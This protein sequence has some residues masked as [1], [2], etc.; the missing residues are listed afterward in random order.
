MKQTA[1]LMFVRQLLYPSIRFE[2]IPSAFVEACDTNELGGFSTGYATQ[3]PENDTSPFISIDCQ[4]V[5][6]SFDPNDKQGFP[7]GYGESHYIE[8]EQDI[9]YLIRF[10]NT[11]TDTAFTVV[12]EDVLSP[13]LELTSI[14]LG[15]SSHPYNLEIVGSDTLKFIFRKYSFSKTVLPMSLLLM[16]L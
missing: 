5:I 12:V 6:G 2:S 9:E 15:A 7:E 13:H 8:R 3:F 10:Q 4:Q 16:V 1:P 14:R 11:G